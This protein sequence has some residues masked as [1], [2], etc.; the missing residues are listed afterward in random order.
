MEDSDVQINCLNRNV[1]P[2]RGVTAWTNSTGDPVGN[3]GT[4]ELNSVNRSEAGLYT[5]TVTVAFDVPP[6][7]FTLVVHCKLCTENIYTLHI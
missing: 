4:L 5:C 3:G 2:F 7:F 1:A 6:Q